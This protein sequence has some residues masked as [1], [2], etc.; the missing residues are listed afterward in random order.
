MILVQ[1]DFLYVKDIEQYFSSKEKVE[2]SQISLEINHEVSIE[3]AKV[4][5]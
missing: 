2:V 5:A 4:A 3:E 1:K